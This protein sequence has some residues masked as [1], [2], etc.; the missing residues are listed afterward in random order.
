[1]TWSDCCIKTFF[2][3]WVGSFWFTNGTQSNVLFPALPHVAPLQIRFIYHFWVPL[4]KLFGLVSVDVTLRRCRPK[5]NAV[6]QWQLIA[7]LLKRKLKLL[8][9][10][11]IEKSESR[12]FINFS[13]SV[14]CVQTTLQPLVSKILLYSLAKEETELKLYCCPH[15]PFSKIS[16]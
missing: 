11:T 8:V 9:P 7:V 5:Q 4:C 12:G 6:F 1:M 10:K 13:F 14:W 15:P 2:W 16:L 3:G